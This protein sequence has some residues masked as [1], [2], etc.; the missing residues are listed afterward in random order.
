[1]SSGIALQDEDRWPW[2]DVLGTALGAAVRKHGLAV[3]ACSAL[4]RSYRDR[5]RIKSATPSLLISLRA[6][7][8]IIRQ[9]MTMRPGHFMPASLLNS[10]LETFEA[11]DATEDALDYDCNEPADRIVQSVCEQIAQRRSD[12]LRT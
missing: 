12:P 3:A 7:P 4:K 11:P 8:E 2:L 10:Q 1:M 5:L 9:R 6:D